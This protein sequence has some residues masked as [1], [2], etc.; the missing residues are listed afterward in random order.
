MEIK[1]L[2]EDAAAKMFTQGVELKY[3]GTSIVY[4]DRYVTVI[5][6]YWPSFS[7]VYVVDGLSKTDDVPQVVDKCRKIFRLE[8]KYVGRLKKFLSLHPL[9]LKLGYDFFV[10]LGSVI[11][12]SEWKSKTEALWYFSSRKNI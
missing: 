4:D 9:S 10:S 11:E 5:Y 6:F 3:K 7:C 1:V 12:L 8:G 2:E